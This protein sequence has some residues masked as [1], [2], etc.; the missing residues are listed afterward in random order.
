MEIERLRK[1]AIEPH[2]QSIARLRKAVFRHFPYLR[3]GTPR[4][5]FRMR[6]DGLGET[7]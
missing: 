7:R 6:I 2:W 3:E 1:A 4:G 5:A